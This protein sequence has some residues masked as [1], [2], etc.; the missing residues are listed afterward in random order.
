[1]RLPLQRARGAQR[2][3]RAAAALSGVFRDAAQRGQGAPQPLLDALVSAPAT[4]RQEKIN[5]TACEAQGGRKE[6][7]SQRRQGAPQPLLKFL[8]D[9][10]NTGPAN[11]IGTSAQHRHTSNILWNTFVDTLV[12]SRVGDF[13]LPAV[14][15]RLRTG[16]NQY[17][18]IHNGSSAQTQCAHILAAAITIRFAAWHNFVYDTGS[19]ARIEIFHGQRK[20]T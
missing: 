16:K 14:P 17:C 2:R 9:C 13:L 1:M 8:D 11:D 19:I 6:Q 10:A 7:C 20:R 18:E 4:A 5:W 3:Q 12:N 15:M